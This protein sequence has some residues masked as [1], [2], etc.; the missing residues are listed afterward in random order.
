MS[1]RTLENSR[2]KETKKKKQSTWRDGGKEY[3]YWW[4]KKKSKI[5]SIIS[6][7]ESITAPFVETK[8]SWILKREHAI[9]D[10]NPFQ[11]LKTLKTPDDTKE[12]DHS[13]KRDT[14]VLDENEVL[15]A[16]KIEVI[17]SK[18]QK[19]HFR[20]WSDI[21]CFTYNLALQIYQSHD[22]VN[23]VAYNKNGMPKK[24]TGAERLRNI[25]LDET[26][27][28]TSSPLERKMLSKNPKVNEDLKKEACIELHTR[29]KSTKLSLTAKEKDE[30]D[31][32]MHEKDKNNTTQSISI[33]INGTKDAKYSVRWD[34]DSFTFWPRTKFGA[35][36][37]KKSREIQRLDG[38]M[39][40]KGECNRAVTMKREGTRYYLIFPFVKLKSTKCI[41]LGDPVKVAASDPGIVTKQTLFDGN[42]FVEYA[43][44][45]ET[46]NA[47][48]KTSNG[49]VQRLFCLGK[50]RDRLQ[51]KCDSFKKE[52]YEN[53]REQ[54]RMKKVRYKMR[55]EMRGIQRHIENLT[56]QC[57]ISIAKEWSETYDELLISKFNVS[58]M[59]RKESEENQKRRVLRRDT[60]R[61]LL[62][63]EHYR[64]KQRLK[65]MCELSGCVM[66]LVG[67]HYTSMSCGHCGVLNR[68]LGSKRQFDCS[69]CGFRMKRDFN[70]ARNI[71][72][73]NVE[74]CVGQV[75]PM[76]D[77]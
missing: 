39:E 31:F 76:K 44:G 34:D 53:T 23:M 13:S 56:K 64:F 26:R 32:V 24:G 69:E 52:C 7:K 2:E 30:N 21:Y 55:K 51:S 75:I 60:T 40:K 42:R 25:V 66:H 37:V 6:S 71:F 27:I 57:H 46:S 12:V 15:R 61:K 8:T 11:V 1:K 20:Y 63:W 45:G 35:V 74:E 18:T 9:I 48:N 29:Y 16:R 58:Q 28:S 3:A 73:M 14:K 49:S 68:E 38:I 62:C 67:E 33:P 5:S 54:K 43:P 4:S 36:K 17:L 72:M 70:G 19:E 41:Q 22:Y 65:E 77:P 10:A 59:V 47:S 50:K